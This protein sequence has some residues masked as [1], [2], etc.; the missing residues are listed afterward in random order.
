VLRATPSPVSDEAHGPINSW[1]GG[2]D[3]LGQIEAIRYIYSPGAANTQRNASISR[4]VE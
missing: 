3:S 4:H 2:I 1:S